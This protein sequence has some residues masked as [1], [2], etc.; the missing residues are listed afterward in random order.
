MVS[1]SLVK[2]IYKVGDDQ[3]NRDDARDL[4]CPVVEVCGGKGLAITN[5]VLEDSGKGKN[6]TTMNQSVN[7]RRNNPESK[8]TQLEVVRFQLH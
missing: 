7:E 2:D 4:E 1:S 5:T 8:L 6:N 3:K